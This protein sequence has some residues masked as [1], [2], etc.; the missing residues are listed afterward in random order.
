MVVSI[1]IVGGF[2]GLLVGI[3]TKTTRRRR[4]RPRLVYKRIQRPRLVYTRR[5]TKKVDKLLQNLN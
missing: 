3:Q 5:T 4:Q 2:I 1:L